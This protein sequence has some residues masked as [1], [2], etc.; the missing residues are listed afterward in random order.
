MLKRPKW[1]LYYAI[2]QVLQSILDVDSNEF[3]KRMFELLKVHER[4][5][6]MGGLH[7]SAEGLM[8]M[9]GMS[10]AYVARKRNMNIVIENEYLPLNYLDFV[11]VSR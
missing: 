4:I 2:G 11:S 5:A 7:K 9:Q 8:F 1:K 10:L 3:N 6:K